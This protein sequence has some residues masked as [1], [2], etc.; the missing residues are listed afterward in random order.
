[1]PQNLTAI[2][3]KDS[4]WYIGFC[5]QIQSAN[6]QG[7]TLQSCRKSLAAAIEMLQE[8]NAVGLF[9]FIPSDYIIEP[10]SI[11]EKKISSAIAYGKRMQ[12]AKRRQVTHDLDKPANKR[13]R[14][15]STTPRNRGG[16]RAKDYK[17][18]DKEKQH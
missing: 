2:Y 13:K 4:G 11:D 9:E 12:K 6:G 15:D 17:K 5:L 1:M 10:L 18:S 7:K 3:F 8:E 14:S 16:N